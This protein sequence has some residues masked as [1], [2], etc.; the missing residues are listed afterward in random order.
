[1]IPEFRRK[2]RIAQ[3]TITKD[4]ER[5]SIIEIAKVHT[6]RKKLLILLVF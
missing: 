5:K 2:F 1:M 3:Y 4:K 6:E